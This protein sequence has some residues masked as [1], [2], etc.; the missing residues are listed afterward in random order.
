MERLK[1]DW[2]GKSADVKLNAEMAARLQ[3]FADAPRLREVQIIDTPGSGSAVEAHEQGAKEFLNPDIFKLSAAAGNKADA[4]VYVVGCVGRESDV[5][6]LELF[7]SGRLT[8]SGPYNSVCVVHKWDI[9]NVPD[10][11]AEAQR[12]GERLFEQLSGMVARVIPVSGPIALAA[13]AAPDDFFGRI[14][15]V[16][17]SVSEADFENFLKI[18]RRWTQDPHRAEILTLFPVPWA[19]FT[20]IARQLRD[21][22]AG[23]IAAA[24]RRCE[25]Y[26]RIRDLEEFIEERF[27]SQAGIIKKRQT[28]EKTEQVYAP[29][30]RKAELEVERLTD[31]AKRDM[32]VLDQEWGE[33]RA[34]LDGLQ[35]DLE[36]SKEIG[37]QPEL[38]RKEDEHRLR[39]LCDHLATPGRRSQMGESRI[40]SLLELREMIDFYRSKANRSSRKNQRLFEHV[41][42]RLE[43]AFELL[44]SN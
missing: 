7:R 11:A 24:K 30:I 21:V 40:P 12:K 14:L 41:V 15:E 31:D 25:Q 33:H 5:E 10:P 18:E 29:S 22:Q 26:S 36:I 1:E 23:E 6:N 35:M 17:S 3:L 16:T 2:T 32:V 8:N 34:Q 38:V 20:L 27:F 19:S 9:L 43:E 42:T 13:R 28:L 37:L 39:S 44:T 4:I